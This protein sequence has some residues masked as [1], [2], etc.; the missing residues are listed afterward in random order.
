MKSHQYCIK[1]VT[2]IMS[3][4]FFMTTIAQAAMP[5]IE[6]AT[7]LT[8]PLMP[9][10]Q[11]EVGV[12]FSTEAGLMLPLDSRFLI[13]YQRPHLQVALS[14]FQKG[15]EHVL[16]NNADVMEL[17]GPATRPTLGTGRLNN[18]EILDILF[19]YTED[20]GIGQNSEHWRQYLLLFFDEIPEAVNHS[21]ILLS[22][23]DWSMSEE[24]PS[25][26]HGRQGRP[27][28]ERR[29]FVMLFPATKKDPCTL[30]VWSRIETFEHPSTN[31]PPSI[32]FQIDTYQFQG[33]QMVNIDT[34]S[35]SHSKTIALLRTMIAEKWIHG[36]TPIFLDFSS[37]SL[38]KTEEEWFGYWGEPK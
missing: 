5:P 28:S 29:S 4:I 30:I 9:S 14:L 10:V 33:M 17:R 12:N 31:T 38:I 20:Y 11:Q 24:T 21:N 7:P 34:I 26:R 32:S 37:K 15:Q 16:W 13:L 18:N 27:G 8:F 2:I 36:E 25:Y 35:D 3:S 6:F 22:M 1:L 19:C 23:S